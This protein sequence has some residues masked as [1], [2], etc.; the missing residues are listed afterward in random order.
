MLILPWACVDSRPKA[1][2]RHV[3]TL[4]WDCMC[5]A[6][7]SFC[8]WC[9]NEAKSRSGRGS[10]DLFFKKKKID[11]EDDDVANL[12]RWSAHVIVTG[13]EVLPL[14]LWQFSPR[15]RLDTRSM[16]CERS[17]W[18]GLVVLT[19]ARRL[20]GNSLPRLAA[21]VLSRM[22]RRLPGDRK[23]E[24][25]KSIILGALPEATQEHRSINSWSV[26]RS[27]PVIWSLELSVP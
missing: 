15:R 22:R 10:N 5:L 7:F 24:K 25:Q 26:P 4:I 14:A 1:L 21:D 8:L 3:N 18:V 20:Q 13:G 9:N 19:W 12:M 27:N 16:S 6:L 23:S 2:F 17:Y 11:W